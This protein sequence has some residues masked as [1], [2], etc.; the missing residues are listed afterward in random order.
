MS[1]A[2]ARSTMAASSSPLKA[3]PGP[4]GR[5]GS[6]A[7]ASGAAALAGT[8]EDTSSLGR[9]KRVIRRIIAL[10]N[11]RPSLVIRIACDVGAEILENVRKPGDDLNSVD[12][13]RH[14][15]TSRTPVREALMLLEKEGLVEVAPRRRPRVILLSLPEVREIYR[16]RAALLE[17]IAGDVALHA[18]EE[19]IAHLASLVGAMQRHHEH[20]DLSGYIWANV[21][22]HDRNTQLANNRTAKRIIDSL[23]LRTLP[24]RRLSLSQPG[25]LGESLADHVHL[26]HAYEKRDPNLAAALIRFN[27]MTALATLERVL[28]EAPPDVIAHGPRQ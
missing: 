17:L 14:Y 21:E 1:T 16:V 2:S 12:L 3:K 27:H 8:G 26:V 23:L 19:D 13:S 6:H 18:S 4:S 7:A 20:R 5:A 28:G 15:Q 9:A 24:L 11:D 22:F 25:R 10:G